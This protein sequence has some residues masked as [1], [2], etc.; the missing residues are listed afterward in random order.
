MN[1]SEV[2]R[3][4]PLENGI[5]FGSARV[6]VLFRPVAASLPPQLLGFDTGT[7]VIRSVRAKAEHADKFGK[8][9]V[10]L[11]TS[12]GSSKISH[13][14]ARKEDDGFVCWGGEND[15]DVELPVNKRYSSPLIMTIEDATGIRRG[16]EAMAV[17]WLRD[18]AD[19][20]DG[21]VSVALWTSSDYARMRQNYVPLNGDLGA[22]DCDREKMERVGTL[23]VELVFR[24]GITAAHK[25]RMNAADGKGKRMMDAVERREDAG[26]G[27][28]VGQREGERVEGEV[29]GDNTEVGEEKVEVVEHDEHSSQGSEGGEDKDDGDGDG[30]EEGGGGLMSK[31]KGWKKNQEE[32]GKQHRGVMQAKPARTAK[33]IKDDVEEAGQK[34]LHRFSMKT[35]EPDIETET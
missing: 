30:D 6:S 25:K 34:L 10:L 13:R 12:A 32:L 22:W 20:E 11:K 31:L 16:T 2:T 35:R 21:R 28:K 17:L 1:S 26:L 33:W 4:Y 15:E 5:G 29:E 7:L 14:T 3:F 19:N 18:V 23:E 8:C 9:H 27:G 24:P